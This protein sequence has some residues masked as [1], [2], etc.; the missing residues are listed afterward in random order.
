MR[1]VYLLAAS[2]RFNYGDLLFPMIASKYVK[3]NYEFVN[4]ALTA[5]N[6]TDLGAMPSYPYHVVRTDARRGS[7]KSAVIVCGG[8]VLGADWATL[9]SFCSKKFR[10]VYDRFANRRTSRR[11]FEFFVRHLYGGGEP[12]PFL[13]ISKRFSARFDV[14]FHSVGGNDVH[15]S[16]FS[17]GIYAAFDRAV[18]LSARESGTYDSILN[19]LGCKNVRLTPDS[20]ILMS[21][22]FPNINA[23]NE[24]YF[25]FQSRDYPAGFDIQLVCTQLESL[26]RETGLRVLLLP[27]GNCPGHDDE[28]FLS[29]IYANLRC[30]KS[31]LV[32]KSISD[33]MS[34]IAS[35][36]LFVGTSLHGV[37]TAMSFGV[38]Y[39]GIDPTIAKIKDY[40]GT[41]GPKGLDS[42]TEFG[43]ISR[44]GIEAIC[45]DRLAIDS[46]TRL[47]Q[48]G[49]EASFSRIS[50][51]LCR[52]EQ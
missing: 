6:L 48:A 36:R 15:L 11:M 47:Q 27:I 31:M 39:L 41:W 24:E 42:A 40:L 44:R 35:S 5:S 3:G 38:P 45:F 19:G 34:A 33:I 25:C 52:S 43:S 23:R 14:V 26:S 29:A 10:R 4:V 22:I 51:I 9:L 46:S 28:V 2:D 20:G 18:Y 21:K 49:A 50:A 30:P 17:K 1:T 12:N 32:P 13:P 8:E 7:E 37:I 16:E